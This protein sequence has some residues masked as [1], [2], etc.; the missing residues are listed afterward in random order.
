MSFD[1]GLAEMSATKTR[2]RNSSNPFAKS[3]TRS[4]EILI[5]V[6][7]DALMLNMTLAIAFIIRYIITIN[8]LHAR[9][10][11]EYFVD[12]LSMFLKT[13]PLVTVDRAADVLAFSGFYTRGRAYRSRFKV[14]VVA[15][16][17]SLCYLMFGFAD[18]GVRR[19]LLAIPGVYF[20]WAGC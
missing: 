4:V 17:V 3:T 6:I 5:R 14:L 16:A 1:E 10:N 15:Q 20:S 7:S 2:A 12:F 13:S 11:H 8:S 9:T 19:D 18:Y